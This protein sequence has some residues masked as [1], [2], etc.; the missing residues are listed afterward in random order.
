MLA[1]EKFQVL[2]YYKFVPI[3][4]PALLVKHQRELCKTLGLF[5]RILV[6]KEGLNG[7]VSGTETACDEYRHWAASDSRFADMPFKCDAVETHKFP[8]LSV[9]V[10]KEIVTLGM[11]LNTPVHERTGKHLSP[12]EFHLR[13]QDENVLILDGR[14]D[15]E[16]DLGRF[17]GAIR[18]D[19]EVFRDYPKWLHEQNID[20]KQ[21]ILTY[22][23]GGIRCEKLTALLLQE[24]FEDVYQLD[25]G[26][27]NYSKDS[28]AKGEDF[29]GR[30]FVFDQRVSVPINFVNP[31]IVGS[32]RQCDAPIETYVNCANVDCNLLYFSCP[33]C[34]LKHE[35]CCSENCKESARKRQKGGK[36]QSKAS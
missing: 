10:R 34:E 31:S 22:C 2:L 5:G 19:A 33:S 6:G 27:V 4:Y 28:V 23:T 30:C 11:E 32:C 16:F 7:T 9:K 35:R 21:P 15:Y 3:E 17:R 1:T 29:E 20:K 13:M 14:S 18:P 25:G 12:A 26:I 8:K 24:G 36:L